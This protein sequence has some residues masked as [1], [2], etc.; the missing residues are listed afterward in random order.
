MAAIGAVLVVIAPALAGRL[1]RHLSDQNAALTNLATE[2]HEEQRRVEEA[3]VDGER[4]GSP[5][6]C[7]TWWV[8]RSP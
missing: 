7:T 3:A 8:T 6:S 2:L 1:V 5:R 4:A